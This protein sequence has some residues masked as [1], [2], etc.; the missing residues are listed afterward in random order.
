MTEKEKCRLG[1]P[2]DPNHDAELQRE[3][4][5]A[6]DICFRYNSLL[7]VSGFSRWVGK[8]SEYSVIFVK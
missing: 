7:R 6:A 4:A 1:L 3:M 5:E 8:M 2:Y